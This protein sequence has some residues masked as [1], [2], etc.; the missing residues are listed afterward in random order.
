MLII[1][2]MV[3]CPGSD[4]KTNLCLFRI[5]FK[6]FFFL[7]NHDHVEEIVM[8]A[9]KHDVAVILIGGETNVTEAKKN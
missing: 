5:A 7:E 2:C 8:I 4:R 6:N 3:V 1:C 9:V